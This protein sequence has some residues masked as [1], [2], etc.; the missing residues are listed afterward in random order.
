MIAIALVAETVLNR[1]E[2]LLCTRKLE[3]KNYAQEVDRS[4]SNSRMVDD[5]RILDA[6]SGRDYS[7]AILHLGFLMAGE[8]VEIDTILAHCR[9]MAHVPAGIEQF[10]VKATVVS[11]SVFQWVSVVSE[12]G[13]NGY[14]P[15]VRVAFSEI[16]EIMRLKQLTH[17]FTGIKRTQRDGQLLLENK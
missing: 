10:G 13:P 15:F 8:S 17:L 2:F 14:P 16:Y 7:D 1:P 6:F 3:G 4:P 5:M 9:S 12:Y 11:G